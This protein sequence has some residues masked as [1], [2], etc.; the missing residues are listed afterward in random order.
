METDGFY[1]KAFWTT[2]GILIVLFATIYGLTVSSADA[3]A[4]KLEDRLGRVE[5]YYAQAATNYAR[6]D[7]RLKGMEKA[8]G[9]K[10]YGTS[11]TPTN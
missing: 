2:V 9:I 10:G 4:S 5:E 6:I 1:K 7:E 11:A 3:R 8:L